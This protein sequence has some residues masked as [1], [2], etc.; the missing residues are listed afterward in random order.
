MGEP[1]VHDHPAGNGVNSDRDGPVKP[2]VPPHRKAKGRVDVIGRVG[3]KGAGSR[4]EG[5]HFP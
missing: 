1:E 3:N 2:V 4:R 5:R